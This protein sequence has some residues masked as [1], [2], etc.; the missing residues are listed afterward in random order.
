MPTPRE[1]K[2]YD[3]AKKRLGERGFTQP[4]IVKAVQEVVL[5]LLQEREKVK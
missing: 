1:Q 2:I 5:M 3:L 4:E